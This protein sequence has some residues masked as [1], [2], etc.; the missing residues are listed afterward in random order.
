MGEMQSHRRGHPGGVIPSW[1]S[2]ELIWETI[3]SRARAAGGGRLKFPSR[4]SMVILPHAIGGK[5]E[6][7]R[8]Y[9]LWY[10]PETT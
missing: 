1:R 3:V 6:E 4:K 10:F 8:D 5:L 7:C 2:E 9:L